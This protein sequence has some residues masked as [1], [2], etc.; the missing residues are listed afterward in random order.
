MTAPHDLTERVRTAHGDAWEVQGRLREDVGGGYAELPG[1]RLMASGV[2]EPQWNN[3]DVTDPSA[4][5]LEAVRA[6]YREHGDVPWG[7]RVPAGLPW[8][9]GRHLFAKRCMGLLAEDFVAAADVVGLELREAGPDDLDL[10]AD[11]DAAAFDGPAEPTRRWLAPMLAQ[12]PGGPC[13]TLLAALGG[14]P[15]GVATAT[16]TGG[17][18]GEAVYVTG[19]GVLPAARRRGVASALTSQL[20]ATAFAAGAEL[21]HLNPDTDAAAAV[22]TRLGFV[23]TG[24][25]DVYVDL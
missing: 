19:V 16:R 11:V 20:L 17:R 1:I 2:A 9:A 4:V 15:V 13:R 23:E 8:T 24:G 14:R 5:D 3:G 21:A 22:Y 7:V 10:A 25:F 6:F 12:G 18:A